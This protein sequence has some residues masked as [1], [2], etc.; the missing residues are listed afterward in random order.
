MA[1]IHWN[2]QNSSLNSIDTLINP[3]T[4]PVS[5][6]PEFKHTPVAIEACHPKWHGFLLTRRRI[7]PE[8]A[9]YWAVA[10]CRGFWRYEVAGDSAPEDWTARARQLL[11]SDQERV[12]WIEYH[13]AAGGRYRA[14]RLV[15][16]ALDSCLFIGPGPALPPR[17]WLVGLFAEQALSDHQRQSLLLGRPADQVAEQGEIVCAC[18]NVG[19][20]TIRDVIRD[21]KLTSVD[22]IGACLKAGTNC[23]SCIPELHRL[24]DEA[25]QPALTE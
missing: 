25:V 21:K 12:E 10:R 23:G 14:A 13:D 19:V 2:A 20:N 18:H 1:R 7:R 17:D 8:L 3:A 11:C 9:G 6:Q 15:D 22:D 24:L 16:N 5:G 4:D